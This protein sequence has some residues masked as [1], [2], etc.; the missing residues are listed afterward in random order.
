MSLDPARSEP[1]LNQIRKEVDA[2][3][4]EISQ[5]TKQKPA[6][7]ERKKYLIVETLADGTKILKCR[8][9]NPKEIWDAKYNPDKAQAK[10]TCVVEYLRGLQ[11]QLVEA[12]MSGAN[13]EMLKSTFNATQTPLATLITEFLKK[14]IKPEKMNNKDVNIITRLVDCLKPAQLEKSKENLIQLIHLMGKN[15]RHDE[16]FLLLKRLPEQSWKDV[17][18]TQ[19]QGSFELLKRCIAGPELIQKMCDNLD[20]NVLSALLSDIPKMAP[21]EARVQLLKNCMDDSTLCQKL[22]PIIVKALSVDSSFIT[23]FA[24]ALAKVGQNGEDISR[25]LCGRATGPDKVQ[26]L[27][28]VIQSNPTIKQ[29]VL[30]AL[31]AYIDENMGEIDD[32]FINQYS[33]FIQQFN[34]E[35]RYQ[36]LIKV[37]DHCLPAQASKLINLFYQKQPLTEQQLVKIGLLIQ[38]VDQSIMQRERD[39]SG[40]ERAVDVQPVSGVRELRAIKDRLIAKFSVAELP[41]LL[42]SPSVYIVFAKTIIDRGDRDEIQAVIRALPQLQMDARVIVS[43]AI[44]KRNDDAE[45]QAILHDLPTIQNKIDYFRKLYRNGTAALKLIIAQV[46]Q[47]EKNEIAERLGTAAA[48][49]LREYSETAQRYGNSGRLFHSDST[50]DDLNG[51]ERKGR[52]AEA[53]AQLFR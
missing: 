34:E 27:A 15:G 3:A 42:S 37:I 47:E 2:A 46:S 24:D 33:S 43:E 20:P 29:N 48:A 9:L 50:V 30:A 13:K 6:F 39:A 18:T 4:K 45:I 7:Y 49:A 26:G 41:R 38:K 14:Q 51:L 17:L 31:H 40:F 52:E 21:G 23:D 35:Q 44:I 5:F 16:A 36:T 25:Y 19:N 11:T 53:F 32:E 1:S 22:Q 10:L 28:D 12:S 8:T